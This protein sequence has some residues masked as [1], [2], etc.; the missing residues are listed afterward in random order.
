MVP[1]FLTFND[2]RAQIQIFRD[3]WK[4]LVLIDFLLIWDSQKSAEL[5]DINLNQGP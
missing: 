4:L 3:A 2:E 5:E 1:G